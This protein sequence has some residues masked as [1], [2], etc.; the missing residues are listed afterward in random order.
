LKATE[1]APVSSETTITTASARAIWAV[2]PK[3]P[4]GAVDGCCACVTRVEAV[5][6]PAKIAAKSTEKNLDMLG[7]RFRL[8]GLAWNCRT[9]MKTK[10]RSRFVAS[11]TLGGLGRQ[12]KEPHRAAP[13]VLRFGVLAF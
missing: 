9:G 10:G 5:L 1:I 4:A 12:K 7:P 11:R 3:R 8:K 13:F 6:T 2:A